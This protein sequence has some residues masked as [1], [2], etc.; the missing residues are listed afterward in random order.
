MIQLLSNLKSKLF[1]TVASQADHGR[2][3]MTFILILLYHIDYVHEL[4]RPLIL[5]YLILLLIL[6][7]SGDTLTS[8]LIDNFP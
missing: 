8:F 2:S 5:Y 6:K 4:I 7:V 1:E 3:L